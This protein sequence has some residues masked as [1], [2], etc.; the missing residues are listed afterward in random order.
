MSQFRVSFSLLEGVLI[1][2]LLVFLVR[3][4]PVSFAVFSSG[5]A[6][7]ALEVVLLLGFQILY[8]SVYHRLGLIVTMF[9]LG[10]GIGSWLMNR[11]LAGRGRRDLVLLELAIALAAVGVPACLAWLG[12]VG[13]GPAAVIASQAVI[14]LLTLVVAVLVGLVFPLA[15]K[16][17][18]HE[19]AA[20]ASRL[21]TAD[22][23]GAALG[24]LLV[25]TLLVPLIGVWGVCLL[26]A[27][28]NLAGGA[29]VGWRRPA[30]R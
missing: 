26:A 11:S 9:M 13:S 17:D 14:Y 8:G 30:P 18:F 2:A 24:A 4:R 10:L 29:A 3:L 5:L 16:L 27:V 25:S 21:Y 15:A 23:L 28:L 19:V 7:S 20:T 1:L 22:Y 6:A 12:S